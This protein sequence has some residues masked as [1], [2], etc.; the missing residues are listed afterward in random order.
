MHRARSSLDRTRSRPRR[1][2]TTLR[3]L[4]HEAPQ[5]H[6]WFYHFLDAETGERRLAQRSFLDRHALLLAGVLTARQCLQGDPEIV[7]LADTI[8]AGVDFPWMMD[9]SR[10]YFSHGW[11]PE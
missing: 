2:A 4:A 1:V 3:F 11:T 6:G 5:K 7:K 8:Y 9:G 10:R